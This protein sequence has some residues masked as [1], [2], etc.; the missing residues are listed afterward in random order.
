L[1]TTEPTRLHYKL[2]SS[3]A[4]L[5]GPPLVLVHGAGGDLMQWPSDLRR[6]AGRAVYALDLPGHGGSGG[7]AL[8]DV[9]ACAEALRAWAEGLALPPFVLVGHSMGGAVALAF[10]LSHMGRL[11]GLVLIS[12]GARLRVAPQILT[13]IRTDPKGTADLLIGW[14]YGASADPNLL[15]LGARRLREV[16]PEVLHAD[17]AACDAFDRREDVARITTPTLIVCGDADV[18]TPLKSSQYL[19][20][21]IAGSQ[22]IVIPGAGHMV[23]LQ[24]PAEVAHAVNA[25]LDRIY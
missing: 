11:A 15:R 1:A 7:D 10:A 5:K 2:Y 19:H 17:F 24:N 9:D 21:Q 8:A 3:G 20:G 22:L 6:M 12:T 14:M 25:F 18:M 23:A 13:G 16:R 4:R